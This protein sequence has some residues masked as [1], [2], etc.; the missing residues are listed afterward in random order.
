MKLVSLKSKNLRYIVVGLLFF[1]AVILR[2]IDMRFSSYVTHFFPKGLIGN[3]YDYNCIEAFI[4]LAIYCC[5]FRKNYTV[6]RINYVSAYSILG[7]ITLYNMI[8]TAALWDLHFFSTKRLLGEYDSILKL[9]GGFI[10]CTYENT[11]PLF[12]FFLACCFIIIT[13]LTGKRWTSVVSGYLLIAYA[14]LVIPLKIK[15]MVGVH[16]NDSLFYIREFVFLLVYFVVLFALWRLEGGKFFVKKVKKEVHSQYDSTMESLK[17]A[18]ESGEI[19]VEEYQEKR[20]EILES[21]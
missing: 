6:G 14:A 4:L 18:F 7:A 17:Q 13:K 8:C 12:I 11:V 20:A 21:L 16:I 10:E 9:S 1:G 15:N 3:N 5:F 19:T 2:C